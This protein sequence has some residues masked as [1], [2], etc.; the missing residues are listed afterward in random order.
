MKY[1]IEVRDEN[2]KLDFRREEEVRKQHPWLFARR[3]YTIDDLCH[4]ASYGQGRNK[5][6]GPME[7]GKFMKKIG[8]D[9]RPKT[10]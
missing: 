9:F 2:G 3:E 4:Y 7:L 1:I 8:V 5:P 10:W 6:S